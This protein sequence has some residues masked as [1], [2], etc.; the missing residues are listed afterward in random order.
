MSTYQ[1]HADAFLNLL[2]ADAS[3]T[4]HD[5]AATTGAVPPYV[6]VYIF[7][8]TPDGLAAPDRVPLTGRSMAANLWAYCHCVGG[9]A[10]AARA[11]AGRVEAAV[12]DVT[13][14]VVGRVCFPIRWREGSP[15][16]RDEDTGPLV[17]DLVDVYS[18][19]SVAA[20]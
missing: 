6:L 16:R 2:R 8:E 18:F 17:M 11:V 5:G 3:L 14:V 9:N 20:S 1:D 15:P 4:V 19:G 10:T 13:P 12:L 7:R